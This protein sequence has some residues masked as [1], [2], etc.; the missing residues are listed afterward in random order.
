MSQGHSVSRRLGNGVFGGVAGC[1]YRPNYVS[2]VV[3]KSFFGGPAAFQWSRRANLSSAD[4]G[5]RLAI[6]PVQQMIP[7]PGKFE[8]A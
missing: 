7:G 6:S 5:K 4:V 1:I 2:Q 3:D 8:P